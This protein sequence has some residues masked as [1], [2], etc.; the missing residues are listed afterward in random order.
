LLKLFRKNCTLF[1]VHGVL[2]YYVTENAVQH[3]VSVKVRQSRCRISKTKIIAIFWS[4][5]SWIYTHAR[6]L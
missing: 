2:S 3:C 5:K 1:S 4:V 6:E